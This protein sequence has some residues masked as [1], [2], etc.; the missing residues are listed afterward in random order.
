MHFLPIT[1]AL[2]LIAGSMTAMQA[3]TNALLAR[4]MG[5]PVS[6]ALVSFLVGTVAL[7]LI[8]LI[9]APRPD[10]AAMKALPWW[11]WIGGLYGAVF[12]TV[13]AFAAPRIGVGAL[14]ITLIAGQ[15][16]VAVL[17]DHF[18]ALGLPRRPIDVSRVAG[19]A[20]VVAGVFLVRR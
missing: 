4:A 17:L 12:V 18:G 9:A 13:A 11:A 5:S 15:L 6:A 3:P 7:L 2:V 19:L 1:F 10:P 14:L 20:L 16:I 8:V